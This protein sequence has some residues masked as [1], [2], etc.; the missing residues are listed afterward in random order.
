MVK[1]NGG[2]ISILI[3][4][5]ALSSP[6]HGIVS[7]P[8]I[9]ITRIIIEGVVYCSPV[10]DPRAPAISNATVYLTCAGSTTSL[11]QAVTNTTGAFTIVLNIL[12]NALFDPSFCGLGV[13]LPAGNCNLVV[14]DGVLSATFSLI[15]VILT[16]S[17][18][19]AVFSANPFTSR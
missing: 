7:V 18:N 16:S 19:T 8:G 17:I 13:N 5:A 3:I 2:L 1:L 14:P 6:S 12:N 4:M 9:N 10:G 15:N 11:G